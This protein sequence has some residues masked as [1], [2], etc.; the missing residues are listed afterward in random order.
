M[1]RLSRRFAT[2]LDLTAVLKVAILNRSQIL[3]LFCLNWS[4]FKIIECQIKYTVKICQFL[5]SRELPWGYV[6]LSHRCHH[7]SNTPV[8]L[9]RS[10]WSS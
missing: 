10:E 4:F 7:A 2:I 8:Y 5:R 6:P 9:L 3:A 1:D